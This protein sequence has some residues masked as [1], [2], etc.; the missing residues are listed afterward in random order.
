VNQC[1]V[2]SI[3]KIVQQLQHLMDT[4]LRAPPESSTN[5]SLH[6]SLPSF[7]LLL[8]WREPTGLHAY[9]S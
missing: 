3:A 1:N 5:L 8:F 2:L 9:V 4:L 6:Q 7:V